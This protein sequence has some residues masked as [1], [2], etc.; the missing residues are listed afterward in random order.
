MGSLDICIVHE[1][2]PSVAVPVGMNVVALAG[3]L[4]VTGFTVS[5]I[6]ATVPDLHMT[7]NASHAAEHKEFSGLVSW[8]S[9]TSVTIIDSYGTS[10]SFSIDSGTG[11]FRDINATER[12]SYYDLHPFDRVRIEAVVAG[13]SARAQ[14]ILD[15]R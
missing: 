10:R 5:Q 8:V 15:I 1:M 2:S 14:R 11:I 3:V 12:Q 6:L 7:T 9:A 4:L 13:E